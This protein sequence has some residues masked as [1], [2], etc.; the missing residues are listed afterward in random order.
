MPKDSKTLIVADKY[1]NMIRRMG[2]FLARQGFHVYSIK[3][4]AEALTL[5]R[6]VKADLI[7][8]GLDLPGM[9]GEAFCEHV[10]K[11]EEIRNVSIIMICHKGLG[12]AQRCA[13]CRANA[14]L[15][16]DATPEAFAMTARRLLNISE[17]AGIRVAVSVRVDGKDKRGRP[18][19][20]YSENLS[21]TGMLVESERELRLGDV[22]TCS[23]YLDDNTQI[24]ANA[25][26]VRS[27]LKSLSDH[28]NQYGL[29]FSGLSGGV[30][31]AIETYVKNY[32]KSSRQLGP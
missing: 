29:M 15:S 18:F 21:A 7:V 28:S 31:E 23:F 10:R 12:E 6:K 20:S 1:I 11:D 14:F 4:N 32:N 26:V 5:Q 25:E 27:T 8:T 2:G 3:T 24:I 17:R 19:L 16:V 9:S 13:R 30:L 22:V